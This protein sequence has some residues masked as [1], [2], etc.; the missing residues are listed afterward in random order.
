MS[1]EKLGTSTTADIAFTNTRV[2]HNIHLKPGPITSGDDIPV[3]ATITVEHITIPII[4]RPQFPR[5]DWEN[6][7]QDLQYLTIPGNSHPT[8]ADIDSYLQ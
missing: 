2:F 5:A 8:K 3:I 1:Q 7:K 6:Y 4:P